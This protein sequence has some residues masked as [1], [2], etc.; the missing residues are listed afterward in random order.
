ML[1][2]AIGALLE[3]PDRFGLVSMRDLAPEMAEVRSHHALNLLS[4]EAVASAR[5]LGA[6]V[7]LSTP[8]P[9]LEA[10]LGAE[11]IEVVSL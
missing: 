9:T 4:A 3:L 5:R 10:A 8:S 6:R 11:N 1:E 2:R 7:Y